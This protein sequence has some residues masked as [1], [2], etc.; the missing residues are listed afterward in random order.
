MKY[1]CIGTKPACLSSMY[2][3]GR[4]IC[5]SDVNAVCVYRAENLLTCSLPLPTPNTYLKTPVVPYQFSKVYVEIQSAVSAGELAF[6][7][8]DIR[9]VV[10]ILD[11]RIHTLVP[12]T[13]EVQLPH[14]HTGGNAG[15][16][17]YYCTK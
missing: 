8:L 17:V 16:G 12:A 9:I 2:V 6:L 15:A 4:T 13:H 3:P 5:I 11:L 14:P 10:P 7:P 1:M